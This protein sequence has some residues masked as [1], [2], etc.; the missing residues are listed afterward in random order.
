M[1]DKELLSLL[2]GDAPEPAGNLADTVVRTGRRVRTRRRLTTLGG[3]AA[4]LVAAGLVL[5]QLA[6]SGSSADKS[7][8]APAAA[9]AEQEKNLADAPA[10]RVPG[11]APTLSGDGTLA[12]PADPR[13]A[14]Y[15]AALATTSGDLFLVD[16]TTPGLDKEFRSALKAALPGRRIHFASARTQTTSGSKDAAKTTGAAIITLGEATVTGDTASVLLGREGAA[17]APITLTW[18]DGA[19]TVEPAP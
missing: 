17:T 12:M 3:A 15:A 2:A 1:D 9:S 10:K 6:G 18:A 7:A 13:V 19:W 5:P 14:V 11:A 8:A 16:A 4:V